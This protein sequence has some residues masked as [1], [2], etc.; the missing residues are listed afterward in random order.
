MTD[1]ETADVV[2]IEPITPDVVKKIIIKEKPDVLL[3]TMGGQT[4]L[5]I[6]LSLSE[7]GT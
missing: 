1:P 6:A 3:P 5:N 4:A 2:Y 7:N